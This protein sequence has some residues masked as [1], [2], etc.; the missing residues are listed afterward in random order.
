MYTKE[1]IIEVLARAYEDSRIL[2]FGEQVGGNQDMPANMLDR[3]SKATGGRYPAVMGLDL[4][5]YGLQLP[6]VGVNSEKWNAYIDQIADFADKGG[7]V[8]ASSHFANPIP[9]PDAR[10]LCRGNFAGLDAWEELLTEGTPVNKIFKEELLIDGEFLRQLG[11]RGVTVLWR[12]LHE[13]NSGSFWY[14]GRAHG[15]PGLKWM[16]GENLKRLWRYI[17]NLYVSEM[18]LTNLIWVY[19][20]NNQGTWNGNCDVRYYYPG[21]EY[22]D[23][24]GI[25]WYTSNKEE[26]IVPQHS[27]DKIMNYG[28]TAALT[29]FG[30]GQSLRMSSFEEQEKTF[31]ALD[32]VKVMK[33]VMKRGLKIAYVLTW[34]GGYGALY[35]IG[36]GEEALS[37]PF[38]IDLERL[39]KLYK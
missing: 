21:D 26:I 9:V 28:M 25:D 12:P 18:G 5:C 24:V 29:E 2:L 38:C 20:P 13:A 36:K 32:M 34:T 4:A 16:D 17:Y 19:A 22:V 1:Q 23:M 11:E 35:S 14:C 6:E 8:T 37:D 7:I 31:N 15:E 3:Y 30:P 39:Q 27:Y 10:A 33:D